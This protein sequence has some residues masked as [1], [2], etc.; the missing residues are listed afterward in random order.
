[1]LLAERIAS[2]G[3]LFRN[4]IAS[5]AQRAS[6]T[7]PQ[8][9]LLWI[10]ARIETGVSQTDLAAG[11]ALSA[12]HVSGL[13]EQLSRRRLIIGRRAPSDRRRQLWRLTDEGREVV[14]RVAR[15]LLPCCSTLETGLGSDKRLQ[16]E[17]GL[18]ELATALRKMLS[19]PG[20]SSAATAPC[21]DPRAASTGRAD[22]DTRGAA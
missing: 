14:E 9:A 17:T 12:A 16:L 19:A 8:F 13:V 18:R 4:S 3:Q 20:G 2:C 10:C 15:E 5:C 11:L 6:I 22:R 21:P 7:E 1:M